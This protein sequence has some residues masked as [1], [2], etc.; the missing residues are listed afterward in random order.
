M[1][2]YSRPRVL[3]EV[4]EQLEAAFISLKVEWR[5]SGEQSGPAKD[6]DSPRSSVLRRSP[7]TSQLHLANQRLTFRLAAL[8]II[9]T[10]HH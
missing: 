10:R 4:Q 2:K 9:F 5:N 7:R 8:Y 1:L 3:I 6:A